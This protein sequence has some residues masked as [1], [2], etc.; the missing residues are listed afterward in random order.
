MLMLLFIPT[1]TFAQTTNPLLAQNARN[2]ILIETST[3]KIL[4]E[5]NK[6]ERVAIASLTKMMSQIIILEAVEKGNLNWDEKVTTSAYAAGFGGTQIYLQPG[7]VMSARDLMKGISISSAND[8]TVALAERIAGTEEKFVEMMN[9]KVKEFGLKNTN[10]ANC[11]GLDQEG[12]YSTAYDLSIIAQ[13]LLKHDQIL[14]F[15][16][17]TKRSLK[18]I[19]SN[20][21]SSLKRKP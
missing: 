10:F 19:R 1:I 8:A 9:Q 7:E 16:S 4:F 18:V 2:A 17:T 15:S 14:E 3:G 13:E 12:N 20:L 11:T 21:N 5:K 6:D